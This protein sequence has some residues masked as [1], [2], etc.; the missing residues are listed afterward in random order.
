LSPAVRV[1]VVDPSA[2]TPPYDHAEAEAL[3]AAGASFAA[4]GPDVQDLLL[5]RIEVGAVATE[6]PTNPAAFFRMAVEH[7]GEGFY[8]DPGNGGNRDGVSWRMIGF[9][10]TA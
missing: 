6:W 8:G 10:V 3:A 9:E 4:L 7:A 1:D 5:R 2:Y